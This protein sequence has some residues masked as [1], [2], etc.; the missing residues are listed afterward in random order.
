MLLRDR[1]LTKLLVFLFGTRTSYLLSY[2]PNQVD[3]A[4][5]IVQY[6]R[7]RPVQGL[8]LSPELDRHW[9]SLLSRLQSAPFEVLFSV[10]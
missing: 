6:R 3:L 4:H 10:W 7:Q 9:D 2:F 5:M 1:V 8:N